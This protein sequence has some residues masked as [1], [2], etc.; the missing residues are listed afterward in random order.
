LREEADAAVRAT[1]VE[2]LG[3]LRYKDAVE[4]LLELAEGRTEADEVRS[5]A[6]VALGRIADRAAISILARLSSGGGGG[7][8]NFFRPVVRE[9]RVAATRAL[10]SFPTDLTARE[11]LRRLLADALPSVRAA[12]QEAQ[13]SP[14]LAVPSA[15]SATRD[16]RSQTWK[17]AGSL[18]EVPLDQICQLVASAQK[19]GLLT[20]HFDGRKARVFFEEGMVVAAEFEGRRDQAA[21]DVFCRRQGGHFSFRPNEAAPERRMKAPVAQCLLEAFRVA[22]EA[23]RG[24][25]AA[26]NSNSQLQ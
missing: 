15:R 9:I 18:A 7:L 24:G 26:P 21:F 6:C 10:G 3:D 25:G 13:E 2:A 1:L 4:V 12:A 8:S 14:L 19:T 5:E 20:L 23:A 17:L 22:D 11:T 16:P